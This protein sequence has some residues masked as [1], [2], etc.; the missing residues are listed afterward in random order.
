MSE[1]SDKPKKT[2]A[3]ERQERMAAKLR[4]NLRRRKDQSRERRQTDQDD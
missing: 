3:E 1:G 2:K 4:E